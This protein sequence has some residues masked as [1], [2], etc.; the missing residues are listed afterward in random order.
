MI[1][2][3]FGF[4]FSLSISFIGGGRGL[5]RLPG[6]DASSSQQFT[7]ALKACACSHQ[8]HLRA[9]EKLCNVLASLLT[10]IQ[11]I[12]PAIMRLHLVPLEIALHTTGGLDMTSDIP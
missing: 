2:S 9:Q 4:S 5:Y 1:R 7:A 3:I 6:M 10:V 11:E 8:R 12:I